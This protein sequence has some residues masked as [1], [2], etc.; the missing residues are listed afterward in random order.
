M[1]EKCPI[2]ENE[3][4]IVFRHHEFFFRRLKINVLKFKT[5]I[6]E[7]NNYYFIT[8]FFSDTFV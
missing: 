5:F 2:L 8:V 1:S 7:F 4:L 6:C 3:I